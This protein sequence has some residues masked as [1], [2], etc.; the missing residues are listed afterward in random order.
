MKK[1]T[2]CEEEENLCYNCGIPIE[3]NKRYCE[4]CFNISEKITEDEYMEQ[5]EIDRKEEEIRQ[6]PSENY[7]NY[8]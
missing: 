8:L 7:P 1:E 6:E 4:G 2:F 3:K 5:E